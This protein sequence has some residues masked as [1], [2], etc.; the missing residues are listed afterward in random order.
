M[1]S[2][3]R[4][5]SGEWLMDARGGMDTE[6]KDEGDEEKED[7]FFIGGDAGEI[8]G[9]VICAVEPVLPPTKDCG[10]G[11]GDWGICS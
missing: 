5:E 11:L 2:L 8:A 9:Y 1:Y 3:R 7:I 4:L 10:M 6:L